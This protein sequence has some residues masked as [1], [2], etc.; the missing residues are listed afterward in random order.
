MSGGYRRV[1]S[2][3]FSLLPSA[4]LDQAAENAGKQAEPDVVNPPDP[5]LGPATRRQLE[6]RIAEL[7]RENAILEK[8]TRLLIEK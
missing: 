4:E 6:D 2:Y 1:P 3:C 5:E 8:V 7:S